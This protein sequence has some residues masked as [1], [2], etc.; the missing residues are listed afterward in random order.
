MV[1]LE[2]RPDFIGYLREEA[3]LYRVNK[4]GGWWIFFIY[5]QSF[6]GGWLEFDFMVHALPGRLGG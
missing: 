4:R 5:V 2:G 1:I 6:A 3:P